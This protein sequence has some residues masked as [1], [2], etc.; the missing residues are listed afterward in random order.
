MKF[1]LFFLVIL[2]GL[3]TSVAAQP[4]RQDS[5]RG[6]HSPLRSYDVSYY[7]LI[8][9]LNPDRNFIVG[10]NDMY[11]T[12][13]ETMPALQID[14]FENLIINKI[15]I[16]GK[17]VAFARDGNATYVMFDEELRANEKHVLTT[18]YEGS[19]TKALNAPW[20]GGFTYKKLADST[21]WV[22]V[23]CE[24]I[25]ASLW[26]PCKDMY[27]DE[28]DSMLIG[29]S[30]PRGYTAVCNGKFIGKSLLGKDKLNPDAYMS[31]VWKV[32]YPINN[33]NVTLN[34]AKYAHFTDY[35]H[36]GGDSLALD[37]YV[38]PNNL[39]K[40]KEQFKQVQP[41]LTCY[42][43]YF[44]KY[45]FWRDG[46]KLVE[47]PY[48]GMEHQ[49]C[50]AYGNNYKKGYLGMDMSGL[51][52]DY[53]IIHESGHEYWGNNVS[54]SDIAEMWIHEGFCTYAESVYVECM[55]GKEQA[56]KYLKLQRLN[57]K[58][59][60]AIISTYEVNQEPP[61]DMYYKGAQLLNNLRTLTK[62]DSIWWKLIHDYATV[63]SPRIA[64]TKEFIDMYKKY[65]GNNY[66]SV[67][68]QYLNHA[69]LPKLMYDWR[70]ENN[71]AL[72]LCFWK[73]DVEDFNMPILVQ[74]DGKQQWIQPTSTPTTIAFG[75]VPLDKISLNKTD[76][77]FG[78][79]SI[80][81]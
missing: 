13:K 58:N 51:G 45:P 30:V 11:F 57:I 75:N 70:Y 6:A 34:I 47:T 69:A 43:K 12:T 33:Y 42:E 59:E 78:Y 54:M 23:S 46:Y 8:V 1:F 15:E 53:I 44:G 77:Y 55:F 16:N 62:N 27:D 64:T 5:L 22:G 56:R 17:K 38:L 19:P 41:M 60:A 52:F 24:G 67:F 20:D 3:S 80:K 18:Y 72:L 49:S 48:L 81:E 4:T 28:P 36:S 29:A 9:Q 14:L 65:T 74:V 63:N 35:Y 31:F 73:A 37:Y 39:D 7:K 68:E 32:S 21:H 79:K 50:I 26:W 25:G 61:Q 71:E 66:D 40:A 76:L 2:I 10:V